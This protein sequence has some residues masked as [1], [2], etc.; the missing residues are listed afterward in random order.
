LFEEIAA[1]RLASVKVGRR[2]L[3]P[4]DALLAYIELLK[5]ET[6]QTA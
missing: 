2:R 3:I 5:A 1:G 4:H 6:A